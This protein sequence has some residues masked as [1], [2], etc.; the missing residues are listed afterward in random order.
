MQ[1][2]YPCRQQVATII[3]IKVAYTQAIAYISIMGKKLN[4]HAQALGRI[5]GKAGRG[6]AKARTSEQARAAVMARWNKVNAA[7]KAN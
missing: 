6:K 2:N 5:G 7:K 1:L 4:K 3:K